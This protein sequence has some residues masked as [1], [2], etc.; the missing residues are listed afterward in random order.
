MVYK[1][2]CKE[3]E[4]VYIG[5]TAGSLQTTFLEHSRLSSTSLEVLKHLHADCPGHSIELERTNILDTEA[6]LYERGVK[7]AI[8]IRVHEASLNKD[9][10]HQQLSSRWTNT[11]RAHL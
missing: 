3:C 6:N 8:Y 2:S 1:I 4:S 10:G 11:L 5:E 9:R 7:E